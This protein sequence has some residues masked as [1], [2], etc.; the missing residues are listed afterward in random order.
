MGVKI[1]LI[2][3]ILTIIIGGLVTY[4]CCKIAGDADYKIDIMRKNASI[5]M[6]SLYGEGIFCKEGHKHV[7]NDRMVCLFLAQ[8]CHLFA[9]LL[10]G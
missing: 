5:Y 10:Q 6:P 2:A 1:V 7:K 8:A 4:S 3:L 9:I